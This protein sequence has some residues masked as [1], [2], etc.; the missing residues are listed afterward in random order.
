V[1][2]QQELEIA[3]AKLSLA[4]QRITLAYSVGFGDGMERV[5]AKFNK[6]HAPTLT[7]GRAIFLESI[8]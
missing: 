7:E 3:L 5:L 4:E 1:T 2:I 6:S 8:K